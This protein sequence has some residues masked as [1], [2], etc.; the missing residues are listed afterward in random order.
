MIASQMARRLL[1][2]LLGAGLLGIAT[3]WLW[4]APDQSQI[5]Y[6]LQAMGAIVVALGLVWSGLKDSFTGSDSRPSDQLLAL[7]VLAA[8]A[9]GDFVT[10]TLVPLALDIGRLFEERTALGVNT[11]IEKIRSLQVQRALRVD[12]ESKQELWVNVS[13]L[14]VGQTVCVRAGER[15]PVD[16]VILKGTSKIDAA[17]MTGESKLQTV[18]AGSE[19]FAGTQ[20]MQGELFIE[21]TSL[22]ADSALGRIVGLMEEAQL[23]K[24]VVLQRLEEWLRVYVP[25]VIALAATV[26]FFTEDLDRAIAV[27]I[28]SFPSS[29]A[30]AGSATMVSAFSKAASLSLFVKDATVFQT[31]RT[32]GTIVFDKTGTLTEGKQRVLNVVPEEGVDESLLIQ[33]AVQCARHS[34]HPVS[35]AIVRSFSTE[36]LPDLDDGAVMEFPGLGI[37]VESEDDQSDNSKTIRLGRVSWLRECGVVVP[38]TVKS[39]TW[40]AENER[41]LGCLEFADGIRQSASGMLDSVREI[42]KATRRKRQLM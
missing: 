14:A 38:D 5:G 27:L 4:L 7:A 32:V 11:A 35:Q 20:N 39:G 2:D 1:L 23:S 37:Q 33:S 8:C 34:N 24:P 36:G 6:L 22:G 19:V 40:V 13:E 3:L 21:V 12:L 9:Y 30:I 18:E 17:V 28:V 15:I 31:L 42:G 41:C 10:A 26:L 25:V 29:L 16:G